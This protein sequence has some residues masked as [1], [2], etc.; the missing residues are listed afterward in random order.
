ML[1]LA[2]KKN[3]TRSVVFLIILIST[4][5]LTIIFNFF[6][7]I[8]ED[9]INE[10]ALFR[11]NVVFAFIALFFVSWAISLSYD[12]TILRELKWNIHADTIIVS[13]SILFLLISYFISDINEP[14]IDF[15]G[16]N[17]VNYLKA[18]TSLGIILFT[19]GWFITNFFLKQRDFILKFVLS[20]LVSIILLA[21]ITMIFYWQN[22][23]FDGIKFSFLPIIIGLWLINKKFNSLTPPTKTSIDHSSI[24]LI[25]AICSVISVA[26]AIHSSHNLMITGDNWTTL[27]VA[28]YLLNSQDLYEIETNYP[29]MWSMI[30]SGLS[31]VSGLPLINMNS[32]LFPLASLVIVSFYLL[33]KYAFELDKKILIT[34]LLVYR[35]LGGLGWIVRQSVDSISFWKLSYDTQDMFFQSSF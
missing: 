16:I 8:P 5:V 3:K 15:S 22:L 33:E 34:S 28:G 13:C 1:A 11:I 26:W 18:I 20:I 30:A 2:T 4:I 10:G 17:D 12:K 14:I 9:E 23:D 31:S 35:F 25:L 29:I 6:T 27:N 32:L 21:I 19:P 24:L 7:E